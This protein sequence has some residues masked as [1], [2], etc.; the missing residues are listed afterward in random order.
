MSL[1][2]IRKEIRLPLSPE[3]AF[4]WHTHT[5]ALLRLSPPWGRPENIR[6]QGDILS[7]GRVSMQV[8]LGPLRLSWTGIHADARPPFFFRDIQ[9]KGPFSLWEHCH[10]FHKDPGGCRMEDVLKYSLPGGR[11][12][13]ILAGSHVREKL[14]SMF[15]WRH[16]VLRDDLWLP[17]HRPMTILISGSSGL[18]AESL[19]PALTTAGHRVIPL[20]RSRGIPGT[21]FW[22]PEK[23]ELEPNLLEGIHAVVHLGGEPIGDRAWTQTKKQRIL[24]SR[25]QGTRLLADAI[26]KASKPPE[27]FLSASAIGYYG[28]RKDTVLSEADA[29]GKG[30]LASVCRLW[31]EEA[32]AVGDITRVACLRIGIGLTPRGGA[33]AR[34]LPLFSSGM[35]GT[36]GQG[37]AWMSWISMEDLVRAIRFCIQ[38]ETIKGPVNLTAPQPVRAGAFAQQLGHTLNRRAKLKV[39]PFFFRA[40]LGEM[41]REI[42]MSSTHVLP[43]KLQSAGF[44]FRYPDLQTALA[45]LLG[46]QNR[47]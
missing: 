5:D 30:F 35:G 42:L 8:P 19:I 14:E 23:G 29:Q 21:R 41:G 20:V 43:C 45:L 33:L 17:P 40:A 44:A 24:Q 27:V 7:G 6:M 25:I 46:K 34:L 4:A 47:S 11:A 9:I 38:T 22:N 31:E 18:V 32:L 15:L 1:H 28:H 12:G 39:P 10:H 26:R 3:E 37:Q 2:E 36:I 16:H 13:D